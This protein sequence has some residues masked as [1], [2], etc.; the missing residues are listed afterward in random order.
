M[1][2]GDIGGWA[3]FEQQIY[4]VPHSD[5]RGIGVFARAAGAPADRNLID[6]Y[7]DVGVEFIGLREDRP[8][9]KFGIAAGYAMSPNGR[10]LSIRTTGRCSIRIGRCEASKVC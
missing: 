10:R 5:D 3:V 7:A 9:D 2:S 4:R 1:L 6:L 8:H